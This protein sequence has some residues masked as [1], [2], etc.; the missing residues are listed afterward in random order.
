MVCSLSNAVLLASGGASTTS[1]S[2]V[3]MYRRS[4]CPSRM[5]SQAAE[6]IGPVGLA[7]STQTARHFPDDLAR[8]RRRAVSSHCTAPPCYA[9]HLSVCFPRA[10]DPQGSLAGAKNSRRPQECPFFPLGAEYPLES[11][12]PGRGRASCRPIG[13]APR[14]FPADPVAGYVPGSPRT[15]FAKAPPVPTGERAERRYCPEDSAR[16]WEAKRFLVERPKPGRIV[17]VADGGRQRTV[18]RNRWVEGVPRWQAQQNL[19]TFD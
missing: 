19:R 13:K 18:L 16:G 10:G 4:S 6:P 14:N 9:C 5:P 2:G 1:L 8:L 7:T 12:G 11:S 15:A 3:A 17:T